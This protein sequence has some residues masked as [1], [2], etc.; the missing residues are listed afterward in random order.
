[1][2]PAIVLLRL[3]R[4]SP[5][6]FL[7]CVLFATVLFFWL[8]IPLGLA[9]RAFFDAARQAVVADGQ[10]YNWSIQRAYFPHFEPIADFLHVLCYLYPVAW[11]VQ[12]EAAAHWQQYLTWMTACWE[13]YPSNYRASIIFTA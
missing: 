12:P 13:I 1:M 6:Y 7:T 3:V 10:H 4:F 9:T 5:R 8:P 11:A 2:S